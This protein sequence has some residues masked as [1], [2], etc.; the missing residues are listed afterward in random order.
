MHTFD[1]DAEGNILRERRAG[2]IVH[3]FNYNADM[4]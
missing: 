4:R 3:E 1:Y 2:Q